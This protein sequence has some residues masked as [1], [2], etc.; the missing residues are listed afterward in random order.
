MEKTMD[1]VSDDT[2]VSPP[3]KKIL[4]GWVDLVWLLRG[5]FFAFEIW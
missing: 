4:E 1:Q 5:F 3:E 2:E